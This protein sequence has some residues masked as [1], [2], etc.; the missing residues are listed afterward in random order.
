MGAA[1]ARTSTQE[2][3]STSATWRGR[4]RTCRACARASACAWRQSRAAGWPAEPAERGL[5]RPPRGGP[6]SG[7]D[8]LELVGDVA[9]RPARV[10]LGGGARAQQGLDGGQ[11]LQDAVALGVALA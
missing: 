10:D 3:G 5:R 8:R 9:E 6:R 11:V 4:A 1:C 7:G 2:A